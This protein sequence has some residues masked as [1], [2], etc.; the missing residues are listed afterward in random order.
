MAL[1]PVIM[2]GGAGT[3]LWPASRPSRPK[4]FIPLAGNRSLFQET[5]LRVAPL[6]QE[7]G[8]LIVV[9]GVGH[10]GWIMDQLAEIGVEDR[11]EILLEPQA[12]DSAAAMAAAALW[13]HARDPMG[14]NIFVASDHH[15][16]DH[17]AFREACVVAAEAARDGRIVTLGVRPSE[18]SSAYGYIS[19]EGPGLTPVRAFREKPDARTAADY[20][21]AGYLW[22][23][24]NFIVTAATLLDEL[25]AN[26]PGVEIAVRQAVA[27]PSAADR[28]VLGPAF[29]DAPKISIDYA[30]MEKTRHASVLEVDFEW[31]DLGAWD[32]IAATGEGDFGQHIFEDAEG[33][34]VRAPDGMLVAALGVRDLAIIAEHDAV[35]VCDLDR[36]QDIKRLVARI[37]TS[38]PQHLDFSR[39]TPETLDAGARRLA[40]WLRLRALPLWSSVGALDDGAFAEALSLD[41]RPVQGARSARVQAKQIWAYAEAGRLGWQGPWRRLVV[42]GA[43]RLRTHFLRADGL[44]CARLG[45]DGAPA[46]GTAAA[47]DQVFVLLALRAA[48]GVAPNAAALEACAVSIRDQIQ[49][50]LLLEARAP[51]PGSSDPVHIDIHLLEACLAW[52]AVGDAQWIAVA[53]TLA[54]PARAR[55][56]AATERAYPGGVAPGRLFECARILD[57]HA[58][59]RRGAPTQPLTMRLYDVATKGVDARIRALTEALDEQGRPRGGRTRLWAQAE[60]LRAALALSIDAA[61]GDRVRLERDAQEALAALWRHLTPDGLWRDTRL[62]ADRFIDEAA[63]ARGL[64][65]LVGVLSDIADHTPILQ[66]PADAALR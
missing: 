8:R 45:D 40:D 66:A 50:R 63:P 47:Y 38:S 19:P 65:H 29:A 24:G 39:D 62:T 11:V 34:L 21:A 36:A 43:E 37:Q 32:A 16:P 3:R 17:D 6:A 58:R 33:C 7:D 27:N 28:A 46:D 59:A 49:E 15:I 18:P 5:A 52:E 26:A 51:T 48:W 1:Y 53:D 14:V 56:E 22:N 2:C 42:N 30:V 41:G 20:I 12:R 55:L 57:R 64:Y 23:S 13:T 4:Q 61:P 9:G 60:W 31:S 54:A 44:C 25:K 35:L 10:R